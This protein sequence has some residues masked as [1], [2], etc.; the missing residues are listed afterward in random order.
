M[1]IFSGSLSANVLV[2][3]AG[4]MTWLP[5]SAQ[6]PG[7]N[8]P[9]P[10]HKVMDNLYYV[11]TSQLG[12]FLITTPEGHILVTSNYET[13]VPVI[14]ASVESLGFDFSDIKILISGHAHPDHIEGDALV[15]QMTGAEVVVGRLELPYVQAFETPGGKEQPVDRI[16]DAGDTVSLGGTTLTAHV[17]AGHT[18]GC[19]AWS[20][21][22]EENGRTYYGFIECSLNG[23][24][25]RYV[26]NAEYP[27]IASDIQQ[28]YRNAKEIPAEVWV[29]SHGVFYGLD[30]KYETLVNSTPGDPN[31]FYDPED[32]KTHVEEFEQIFLNTLVRQVTE[33]NDQ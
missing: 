5:V 6:P 29:S 3:L 25:L 1:K 30:E 8:D 15:K 13:S 31:P 4:V 11:G 18:N 17:Q 26:D 12:S 22:L 27:E 28:T 21:D 2:I 16:I 33:A 7:W 24:F 32:Y 23:Q 9:F 19:L 10:A 20:M 14:K